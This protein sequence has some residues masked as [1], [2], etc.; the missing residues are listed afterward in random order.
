MVSGMF[1]TEAN[2]RDMLVFPG[3]AQRKKRAFICAGF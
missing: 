3:T 1:Q 2:N